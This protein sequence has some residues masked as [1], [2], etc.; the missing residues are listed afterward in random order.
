MQSW[1]TFCFPPDTFYWHTFLYHVTNISYHI[2]ANKEC[3]CIYCHCEVLRAHLEMRRSTMV[4]F[5]LLC[6]CERITERD[7]FHFLDLW[8][9]VVVKR[10]RTGHDRLSA[11]MSR[12]MKL[13]PSPTCNCGLEDQTAEHILQKCPLLQT[14]R[15]NMWTTAVQLHTKLY[16][17][18]EELEKAATFILQTETLS[19]IVQELCESR[20]GR[21]GLSVLTSLLVSVDVKIY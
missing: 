7:D 17:N 21:P 5:P 14:A 11:H 2:Y 10:L 19:V 3:V 4:T 12:K 13:A 8:Q 20:G 9:Q 15:R 1:S 18:K 16:G 6:I